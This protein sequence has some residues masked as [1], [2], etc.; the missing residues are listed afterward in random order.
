MKQRE[1]D[2]KEIE[3]KV[4]LNV[5]KLILPYLEKLKARSTQFA[6]NAFVEIV[7]SNLKEIISPFSHS[8][9]R[10]LQKLTRAEMQVADLVRQG[11][12]T[13]EIAELLGLSP[14][15]VATHRQKIR[16]KLALTNKKINLQANLQQI[17]TN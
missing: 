4:L 5:E 6:E 7:E 10:N 1:Q 16:K 13:K 2:K 9:S 11:K 12:T 3:E 14:A 8:L 17:Q 15:T